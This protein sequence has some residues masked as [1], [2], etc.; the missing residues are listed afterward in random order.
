MTSTVTYEG[1]IAQLTIDLD[2]NVIHGEVINTRDVLT[3][4]VRDLSEVRQAF[5]DT[6]EDYKEWCASLGQSVQKPLSGTMTLRM[7]PELH[8]AA[9]NRAA[10]M[11]VSLNAWIVGTIECEVG[12][13][14]AVLTAGEVD[15]RVAA[16]VKDEVVKVLASRNI[17][18][19]DTEVPAWQEV[20]FSRPAIDETI[21]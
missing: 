4:S 1:Y 18:G 13:R 12:K 16:G 3:F 6:I 7:T 17:F 19:N 10:M 8:Q 21:Q 2:A 20:A 5:A 11:K 14:P 9:A 15:T